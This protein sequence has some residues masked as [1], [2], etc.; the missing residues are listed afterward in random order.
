MYK[1]TLERH[2][3]KVR[4]ENLHN[5][6]PLLK[7]MRQS[8]KNAYHHL[9]NGVHYVVHLAPSDVAVVVHVV[10]SEGPCTLYEK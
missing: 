6:P 1:K 3:L 9:V 2:I 10:Q 8:L 5:F 7:L 4:T